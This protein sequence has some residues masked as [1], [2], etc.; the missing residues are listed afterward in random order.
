ME[1]SYPSATEPAPSAALIFNDNDGS[2]RYLDSLSGRPINSRELTFPLLWL[3]H[4]ERPGE[5]R[6]GCFTDGRN[7]NKCEGSEPSRQACSSGRPKVT[8]HQLVEGK[9]ANG[10]GRVDGKRV[11]APV[12]GYGPGP[13]AK[14]P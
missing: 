6:R 14:K 5:K 11:S 8:P 7:N 1:A 13:C 9:R 2:R 4:L 3:L 12:S 10:G